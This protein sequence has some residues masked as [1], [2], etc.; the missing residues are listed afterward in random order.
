[1]LINAENKNE[2]I[3]E[4]L[5]ETH[6]LIKDSKIYDLKRLL[7][8]VRCPHAPMPA[9]YIADALHHRDSRRRSRSRRLWMT[10]TRSP[11]SRKKHAEDRERASESVKS[12]WMPVTGSA[13]KL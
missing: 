5:D 3:I 12:L 8:L 6:L 4:D 13:S 1:M 11:D 10:A 9:Y 7:D 2:I